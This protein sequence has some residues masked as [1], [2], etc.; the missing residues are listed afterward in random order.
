MLI[1]IWKIC[2]GW[3]QVQRA[4]ETMISNTNTVSPLYLLFK[5]HKNWSWAM[6]TAP[7]VRPVAA[8]NRGQ[9]QHLSEFVSE[10]V[11]PVVDA[12]EGG[13]GDNLY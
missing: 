13:L 6:G 9:N 2:K 11:E 4:R 1:K 8:A 7:P 12:F 10:F 3:N 5:D